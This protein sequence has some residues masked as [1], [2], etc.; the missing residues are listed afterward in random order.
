M[1]A[2]MF[3][4]HGWCRETNPE[5]LRDHYLSALQACGFKVLR[6]VEHHFTP[7]GYIALFLLAESHFAIHT[8]PEC[9]RTYLELSSCVE[10]QFL[11]FMA[12]YT[13]GT[14]DEP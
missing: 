14:T 5:A 11:R 2:Q 13:E 1:K 12:A 3:N 8:F 10:P 7:Y 9:S 6:T 4:W